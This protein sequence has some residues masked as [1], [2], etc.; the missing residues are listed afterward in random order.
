MEIEHG[1]I[2]YHLIYWGWF[3]V[4]SAHPE[5]EGKATGTA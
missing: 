4:N 2:Q 5:R 1:F 3:G